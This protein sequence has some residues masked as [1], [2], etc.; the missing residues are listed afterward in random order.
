MPIGV[1]GINKNIE[2]N[3][4]IKK[5]SLEEHFLETQLIPIGYNT[6]KFILSN[7]KIMK[8][9]NKK[10]EYFKRELNNFFHS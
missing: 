3:L 10:S 7:K 6:L 2:K 8:D 9:I 5:Y 4:K 1:I